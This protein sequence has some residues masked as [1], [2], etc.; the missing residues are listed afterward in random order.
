MGAFTLLSALRLD[1][2]G[3]VG[4]CRTQ[5][6]TARKSVS[7]VIH[8]NG[9]LPFSLLSLYRCSS[10]Y[11]SL[12]P[13]PFTEASKVKTKQKLL[14]TFIPMFSYRS[15]FRIVIGSCKRTEGYSE[16]PRNTIQLFQAVAAQLGQTV[17]RL[18]YF[19]ILL[20]QGQLNKFESV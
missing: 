1:T 18:Q 12:T 11:L 5:A 17:P 19:G 15:L 20:D 9:Q 8:L 6:S 4:L 2:A 10:S 3:S 16:D 13:G 14:L 7:H